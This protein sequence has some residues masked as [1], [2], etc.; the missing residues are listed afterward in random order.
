VPATRAAL[1]RGQ[2][3]GG[4]VENERGSTA[5][6]TGCIFTGN[7]AIGGLGG[8]SGNG[9]DGLG[10]AVANLFG[11]TLTVSGC[12]LAGNQ[13]IGGVGGSGTNGG[14]GFGGALCNDGI[15]T[16]PQ[17]AGTP[18]MLTVTSS[19]ITDNSATSGVPVSGSAGLGEGGGLYLVHG[20]LACLD[21][22][23]IDHL[24]K[25]FASTSDDDI[26]GDFATCS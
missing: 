7:Q 23:T 16:I 22:F 3:A 21:A 4:A 20:G 5:T 2:G 26:F 8:A 9:A 10:G 12:T 15:S 11:A 6:V 14:S 17:N 18:A 19:T 13:A 25:N 24:T 1:T